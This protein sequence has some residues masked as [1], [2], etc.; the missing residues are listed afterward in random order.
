MF[1]FS[2]DRDYC[3]KNV[4][5]IVYSIMQE[6]TKQSSGS[7]QVTAMSKG[8]GNIFLSNVQFMFIP[9]WYLNRIHF[10]LVNRLVRD[11]DRLHVDEEQAIS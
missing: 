1:F 3:V 11:V 2:P 9:Y 6:H 7:N 5:N 8:S 10:L 4:R